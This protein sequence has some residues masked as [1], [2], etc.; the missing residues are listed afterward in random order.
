MLIVFGGESFMSSLGLDGGSEGGGPHN[1]IGGFIKGERDSLS[2]GLLVVK[3]GHWAP[4][5]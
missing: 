1:G 2:H 3:P 5:R 4:L